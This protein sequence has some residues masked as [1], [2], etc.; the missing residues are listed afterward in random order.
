MKI[1]FLMIVLSLMVLVPAGTAQV[2]ETFANDAYRGKTD[3]NV[4]I[5]RGRGEVKAVPDI[6]TFNVGVETEDANASVAISTNAIRANQIHSVLTSNGIA[7]EDIR[8]SEY[9]VY[10]VYNNGSSSIRGYRVNNTI[11][12]VVRDVS[13]LGQLL[14]T[15]I[16]SGANRFYGINFAV[17]NANQLREQAMA[18]AVVDARAQATLLAQAAGVTLGQV[19]AIEPQTTHYPSFDRNESS[20]FDS[21]TPIATGSNTIIADV[22]VIFEIQ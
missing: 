17:S 22:A 21:S 16:S 9:N 20:S 14:D 12:V 19:R 6:A 8:T 13:A 15:L 4:I 1:R 10:P 2:R 3:A 18:E 7:A 11:A 5:V